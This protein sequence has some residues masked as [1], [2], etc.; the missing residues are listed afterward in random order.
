MTKPTMPRP[1]WM[2][3][4]QLPAGKNLVQRCAG[5]INEHFCDVMDI[6]NAITAPGRKVYTYRNKHVKTIPRGMQ[7]HVQMLLGG[8]QNELLATISA[9]LENVSLLR[10]ICVPAGT[11]RSTDNAQLTAMATLNLLTERVLRV[12]PS[13]LDYPG[14][15]VGLLASSHD[16]RIRVRTDIVRQFWV[17][18]DS[19]HDSNQGVRGIDR[20]LLDI[21][22]RLNMLIRLALHV[23]VNECHLPDVGPNTAYLAKAISAK[24]PDEKPVEDIHQHVRDRTRARRHKTISVLAAFDAQLQSPVLSE[25]DIPSP[26]ISAEL[27]ASKAWQDMSSRASCKRSFVPQ[28]R[29]WPNWLNDILNEHRTYP[30]P[31]VP[32][33]FKAFI[34]MSWLDMWR[35]KCNCAIPADASWISRLVPEHSLF[36]EDDDADKLA[37]NLQSSTWGLVCVRAHRIDP[38]HVAVSSAPG[39]VHVRHV[40]KSITVS[41]KPLI[42]VVTPGNQIVFKHEELCEITQWTLLHRR[43][44]TVWEKQQLLTRLAPQRSEEEI[45]KLTGQQ[46]LE[47]IVILSFPD[48]D[49]TQK[50]VLDAYASEVVPADEEMDD[51]ETAALVEELA[52][53]DPINGD[54]VREFREKVARNKQR[55]MARLRSANL[56]ARTKKAQKKKNRAKAKKTVAK[57]PRM[58]SRRRERSTNGGN[59]AAPEAASSSV[60]AP[61]RPDV[62]DPAHDHGDQQ[63]A[64]NPLP[65][66]PVPVCPPVQRDGAN[67]RPTE[68]GGWKVVE[69]TG[70]FI[71]F[72]EKLQRADAHCKLHSK[73]KADRVMSRGPLG[74]LMCWL[75]HDCADKE[76]HDELKP[77]ISSPVYFTERQ[78]GRRDFEALAAQH[79]GKF[80]LLLDTERAARNGSSEEPQMLPCIPVSSR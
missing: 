33:I 78:A 43:E 63:V 75:A 24:I 6:F 7:Y 39:A 11:R 48:D 50:Y 56:A 29:E 54:D 12:I 32:G 10:Q 23:V 17:L 4:R 16:D 2:T 3:G 13:Q 38:H 28:P 40:W 58:K 35:N 34:A 36:Y 22:W 18:I 46:L 71:R 26:H 53:V 15:F 25:R 8:W 52:V 62:A 61:Q 64:Q 9:G 14:L 44:L 47:A 42:A 72:N 37:V 30:S 51:E 68:G 60:P 5:Y 57:R 27:I 73:C 1:W 21:A 80:K 31:T 59:T 66:A 49:T 41:S 69:V 55:Q 20:V 19:E 65:P 67:R 70:G 45:H 74:F 76:A 77:H 79:G